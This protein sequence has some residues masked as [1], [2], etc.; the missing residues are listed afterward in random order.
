MDSILPVEIIRVIS[1][2]FIQM[3]MDDLNNVV[4]DDVP[5]TPHRTDLNSLGCV[6]KYFL[7]EVRKIKYRS[8]RINSQEI[9]FKINEFDGI[10]DDYIAKVSI[11]D[12]H[13]FLKFTR[14]SGLV[15]DI[16]QN[17]KNVDLDLN[18][19]S[20][21]IF[22]LLGQPNHYNLENMYIMK[23]YK[24]EPKTTLLR[25]KVYDC[26]RT[27]RRLTLGFST[28]FDTVD[29]LAFCPLS[30]NIKEIFISIENIDQYGIKR[31]NQHTSIKT[32]QFEKDAKLTNEHMH[33]FNLQLHSL[34]LDHYHPLKLS[35]FECCSN[36]LTRLD[37]RT[38]NNYDDLIVFLPKLI[39]LTHLSV[40]ICRAV[41]FNFFSILLKIAISLKRMKVLTIRGDFELGRGPYDTAVYYRSVQWQLNNRHIVLL[42]VELL[43][44]HTVFQTSTVYDQFLMASIDHFIHG[45]PNTMFEGTF[46]QSN[47]PH[48]I[49]WNHNRYRN[50][51]YIIK[52]GY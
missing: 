5:M 50:V 15:F 36:T 34:D 51:R 26:I 22:E 10:Y 3:I 38:H 29:E 1:D 48:S 39:N 6:S 42:S 19:T 52:D 49:V 9:V 44:N 11:D 16:S 30:L 40:A 12:F 33:G 37:I 20:L 25:N 31:L 46:Q 45:I 13:N 47:V 18:G 14:D 4:V 8:V 24:A 2:I 43:G 7:E 41:S 17:M 23:T 28:D 35:N 21:D 27:L 32:L